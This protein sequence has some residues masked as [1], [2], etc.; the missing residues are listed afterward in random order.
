MTFSS[1]KGVR[2]WPC[3]LNVIH[4]ACQTGGQ[5]ETN[6][7]DGAA[8]L[9]EDQTELQKDM[10][11]QCRKWVE[12]EDTWETQRRVHMQ[13]WQ[14]DWHTSCQLSTTQIF[15]SPLS[16]NWATRRPKQ[17]DVARLRL[18]VPSWRCAA[19]NSWQWTS[20]ELQWCR[21]GET[22]SF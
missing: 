20:V 7:T 4:N 16:H 17:R 18:T 22:S 12:V 10:F 15:E 9:R 13:R 11:Q 8:D 1:V 5:A 2:R 14:A 21:T 6:A 19:R 3:V